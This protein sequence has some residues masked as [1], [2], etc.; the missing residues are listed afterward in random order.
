M[1]TSSTRRPP[2]MRHHTH[3]TCFVSNPS[4]PGEIVVFI[5]MRMIIWVQVPL[6][7]IGLVESGRV[8]L[9]VR[10]CHIHQKQLFWVGVGRVRVG[11][12][13]AE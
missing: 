6:E 3:I 13:S 9:R 8:P 4:P 11:L 1:P 2:L 7:I 10:R 12:R 5:I